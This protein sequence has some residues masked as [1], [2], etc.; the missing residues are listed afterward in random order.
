MPKDKKD[1]KENI[2]Y[3]DTDIE[4]VDTRPSYAKKRVIIP[5][6]MAEIF[7]VSGR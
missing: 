3:D 5:A 2:Y 4:L 7:L 1:K 6:I